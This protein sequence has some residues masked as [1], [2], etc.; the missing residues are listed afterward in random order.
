MSNLIDVHCNLCHCTFSKYAQHGISGNV[1]VNRP[2]AENSGCPYISVIPNT[3]YVPICLKCYDIIN[4]FNL[5][6]DRTCNELNLPLLTRSI[7]AINSI[8]DSI[9]I[10]E[11]I[12]IAEDFIDIQSNVPNET[13]KG[14]FI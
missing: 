7:Y 11:A 13:K 1:F 8:K 9:P 6:I 4:R 5:L 3:Y 2:H 14:W 12:P 10:A